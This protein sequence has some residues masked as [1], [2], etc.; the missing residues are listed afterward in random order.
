[1]ETLKDQESS[2]TNCLEE[3]FDAKLIVEKL[4]K[5]KIFRTAR[6]TIQKLIEL[7]EKNLLTWIFSF[8]NPYH[9]ENEL[10]KVNEGSR[11]L[12]V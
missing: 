3:E 5:L 1:M 6:N 2:A 7:G 11:K 10:Q 4:L 12:N 9:V 8:G